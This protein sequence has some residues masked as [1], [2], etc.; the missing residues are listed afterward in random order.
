MK[1]KMLHIIFT[2]IIV[3]VGPN[4]YA[5][6]AKGKKDK[7]TRNEKAVKIIDKINSGFDTE[8]NLENWMMD[9]KEFNNGEYF[10]EEDL[11]LE[12][13]MTR[14]FE[15]ESE[16]DLE[17]EMVLEDWMTEIFEINAIETELEIEDWMLEPFTMNTQE[18]FDEEE[19]VLEDW[20][21]KF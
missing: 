19:L 18:N 13:W 21:L 4:V 10:F 12:N 6:G 7:E 11:L 5:D 20:M 14:I 15:T 17:T 1:R 2:L 16:M 8:I 3:V 9:I